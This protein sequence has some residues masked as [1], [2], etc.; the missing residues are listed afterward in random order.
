MKILQKTI[1]II[2]FTVLMVIFGWWMIPI[3][4]TVLGFTA[5]CIWGLE[6]IFGKDW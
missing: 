4:M 5:L 6:G 3:I 1:G 2:V